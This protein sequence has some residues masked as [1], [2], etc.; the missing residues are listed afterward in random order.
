MYINV[1]A[2]HVGNFV[3]NTFYRLHTMCGLLNNTTIRSPSQ[4]H[5]LL[6]VV[7]LRGWIKEA[8]RTL[9]KQDPT[10]SENCALNRTGVKRALTGCEWY[11]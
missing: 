9:R 6:R 2:H 10:F 11:N 1:L 3:H 7:T 4:D 5:V 8:T